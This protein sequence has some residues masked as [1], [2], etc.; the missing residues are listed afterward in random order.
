LSVWGT[1]TR[2]NERGAGDNGT[3][4]DLVWTRFEDWGELKIVEAGI[5]SI[6]GLVTGFSKKPFQLGKGGGGVL[7][8][9]NEGG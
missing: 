3:Q 2:V 6:G 1:C 5:G 9:E 7:K 4:G 8:P